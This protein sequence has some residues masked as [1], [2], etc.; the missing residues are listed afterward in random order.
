MM[1][2]AMMVPVMLPVLSMNDNHF[3]FRSI[4]HAIRQKHAGGKCKKTQ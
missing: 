2:A 1:T 4:R 3:L